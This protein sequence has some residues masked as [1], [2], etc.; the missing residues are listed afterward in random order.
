MRY[1]LHK[2]FDIDLNNLKRNDTQNL[3]FIKL[4]I[5][6]LLLVQIMIL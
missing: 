3:L 4:Q 5:H 2:M 1:I 6:P